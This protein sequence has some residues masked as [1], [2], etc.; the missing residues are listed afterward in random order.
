MKTILT[1]TST[2]F[3]LSLWLV[4]MCACNPTIS[5]VTQKPNNLDKKYVSS[6]KV[7]LE[8]FISPLSYSM[9]DKKG[10]SIHSKALES[11]IFDN[12]SY[13]MEKDLYQ[14]L[15][16]SPNPKK[17]SY[18]VVRCKLIMHKE[19]TRIWGCIPPLCFFAL[20]GLTPS[21]HINLERDYAFEICDVFGNVVSNYKIRGSKNLTCLLLG[22]DNYEGCELAAFKNALKKF[23]VAASKDASIINRKLID[24]YESMSSIDKKPDD[25]ILSWIETDEPLV[26]IID[27]NE[28]NKIIVKAPDDYAAIGV[29][30]LYNIEN[31]NFIGAI[32]DLNSYISLNPACAII[33]PYYLKAKTLYTLGRNDE[34]LDALQFAKALQPNDEEIYLLEGQIFANCNSLDKAISAFKK[35]EILNPNNIDVINASNNLK[36][37]LSER[38]NSLEQEKNEEWN[39]KI[40]AMHIGTN[41]LNTAANGLANLNNIKSKQPISGSSANTYS[42]S[43]KSTT[44]IKEVDCSTCDGTGSVISLSAPNF[45]GTHYCDECKKEVSD[46]HYHKPCMSCKGSGKVKRIAY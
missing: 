9:K 15:F 37:L 20:M 18:G 43:N 44:R 8:T 46:S 39:R 42:T 13:L 2:F 12:C 23:E 5:K 27:I 31:G 10:R 25:V 19:K 45:G 26:S 38:L 28:L 22:S 3:L 21:G 11:Y 24:A 35:V 34:A 4:C 6:I 40:V 36:S 16:P 30:A 17:T 41:A 32:E 29:R 7:P 33:R 1:K 14:N